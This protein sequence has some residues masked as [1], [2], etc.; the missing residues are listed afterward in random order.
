[1]KPATV[2]ESAA[3]AAL[4]RYS[5]TLLP[6]YS[7]KEL[8]AGPLDH[9]SY[10]HDKLVVTRSLADTLNAVNSLN[11][12]IEARKKSTSFE[13]L[14]AAAQID[15]VRPGIP[16]RGS[17]ADE[18]MADRYRLALAALIILSWQKRRNITSKTIDDLGCYTEAEPKIGHEGLFDLTPKE[19]AHDRHCSLWDELKLA[20]SQ[21]LL[22][23]MRDAIPESSERFEDK[24]RRKVLK[25]LINTPKIP[26]DRK[27]CRAL[28]D[29]VFAFFCPQDAVIL[30]T[31]ISDHRRLA[32]AI[33]KR[34]VKP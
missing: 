28:G 27:Q 16:R 20:T 34:A 8:K 26:L 10:V 3:K 12:V 9:Y 33:G 31:N 1:L 25:H 29:A 5:E 4:N 6:V 11:P 21:H 18:E 7:I 15:K 23:A 24:E 17:D 2:K 32:R 22:I 19:C 14:A 13:A 30:T